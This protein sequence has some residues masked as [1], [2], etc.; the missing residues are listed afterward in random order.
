[1]NKLHGFY[2]GSAGSRY[3]RFEELGSILVAKQNYCGTV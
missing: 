1:M 2:Q 3:E